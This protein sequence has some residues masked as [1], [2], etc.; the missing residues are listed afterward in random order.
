MAEKY[1]KIEAEFHFTACWRRCF[2]TRTLSPTSFL[3]GIRACVSIPPVTDSC[4]IW[5]GGFKP[6]VRS[7]MFDSKI[8]KHR[9]ISTI[10]PAKRETVNRLVAKGLMDEKIADSEFQIILDEMARYNELKQFARSKYAKKSSPPNSDE[11]R[12]HMARASRWMSIKAHKSHRQLEIH[13][14]KFPS[15]FHFSIIK[16]RAWH[17]FDKNNVILQCA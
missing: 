6:A 4:Y 16:D 3:T 12:K 9:S 8:E 1:K 2:L 10:A 17:V 7:K 11:I 5:C 13:F 14:K 15:C